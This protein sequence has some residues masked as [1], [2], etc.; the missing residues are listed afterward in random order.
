MA[1]EFDYSTDKYEIFDEIKIRA[2]ITQVIYLEKKVPGEINYR[3]VSENE[4]L[5]INQE[6][7]NHDY[8]TDII[9]FDSCFVNIINGDIFVSLD[10]IQSNSKKLS[11][12]RTSEN[13][14]VIIHGIMHLCGYNDYSENEKMLMRRLEDKYLSYLEKL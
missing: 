12:N 1:I 14:R 11:L 3:F 9:T 8:F 4:I 5:K 13:H 10:T 2:W 7:L 6:H